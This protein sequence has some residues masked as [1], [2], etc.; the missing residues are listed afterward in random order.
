M[1]SFDESLYRLDVKGVHKEEIPRI[2]DPNDSESSIGTVVCYSP[3][4]EQMIQ[5]ALIIWQVATRDRNALQPTSGQFGVA[6]L[7]CTK[8]RNVLKSLLL[9]FVDGNPDKAMD[10]CVTLLRD[11]KPILDKYI[12]KWSIIRRPSSVWVDKAN[13][14]LFLCENGGRIVVGLSPENYVFVC[15]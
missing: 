3:T 10:L 14:G 11:N 2:V 5:L 4:K 13:K 6:E 1:L 7:R 15:E 12:K 8:T 9:P